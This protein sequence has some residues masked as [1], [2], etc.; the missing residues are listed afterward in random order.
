[1]A[2]PSDPP[3]H[4][5]VY[6]T[7][8]PPVLFLHGFACSGA[9]WRRQIAYFAQSHRVV[10]PDLRGHGRSIGLPADGLEGLVDDSVEIVLEHAAEQP[11]TIVGHSM[12][13]RIALG[14]AAKIPD[15]VQGV[16]FVDGSWVGDGDPVALA[17]AVAV[18][19]DADGIEE[20]LRRTFT[21]MFTDDTDAILQDQ[22]IS[23]ALRTPEEVVRRLL[24]DIFWWDAMYLPSKV[25]GLTQPVLAIQST[26]VNNYAERVPVHD[27]DVPWVH[28]L[29]RHVSDLTVRVMPSGHFVMLERA[30][31]VNTELDVFF[32]ETL[33]VRKPSAARLAG[34]FR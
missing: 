5:D 33:V 6:G 15:R 10:V 26:Y 14:I 13:C 22:V 16:V 9:D 3:L 11:C 28:L 18:R 32:R 12:G 8:G 21:Q 23:R 29:R 1:M 20:T 27:D 19:L 17:D 25:A 7:D 31:D 24:P 4:V 2:P 34:L 30:D